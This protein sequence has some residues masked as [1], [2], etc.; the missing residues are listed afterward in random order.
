VLGMGAVSTVA[1]L[2]PTA[3]GAKEAKPPPKLQNVMTPAASLERLLKGNERYVE[4]EMLCHDFKREREA[5]ERALARVRRRDAR[6]D[7]ETPSGI[8][9][10][11]R[12]NT[13]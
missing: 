4:G 3:A 9:G 7:R 1:L 5:L 6:L 11:L 2:L 10:R 13:R 12:S 8:E